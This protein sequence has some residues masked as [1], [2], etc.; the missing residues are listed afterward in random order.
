MNRSRNVTGSYGDTEY[1]RIRRISGLTDAN[2]SLHGLD[3]LLRIVTNPILEHDLDL[4]DISNVR[5]GV[6]FHDHQIRLLPGRDRADACVFAQE[7]CAVESRNLNGFDGS[8]PGLNQ[9]LDLSMIAKTRNDPTVA[10]RI[11]PRNQ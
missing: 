8:E 7:L 6:S 4:F 1:P 2:Q 9:Q 10:G 11:E 3:Q 5:C